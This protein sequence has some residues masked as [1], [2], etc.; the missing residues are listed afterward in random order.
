MPHALLVDD[1]PNFL[2]AL[3]ELIEGQ[4]FI[5]ETAGNLRDARSLLGHRAP[6]VALVDL[7]LP[8]GRGIDL[9]AGQ[10]PGSPTKLVLMTGAAD[11]ESAVQ[12]LRMGA[13]DYL[14]KPLDIGRLKRV[15]ADL[16]AA[17]FEAE[18]DSGP[19][20][21]TAS[22]I[23]E[24]SGLGLLLGTSPPMQE[25]AEMLSR[26]APTDASVL[27]VGESGA[28]KDLAAQTVHLLSRRS[29]APFLPLNCGAISPTLIE[30]ELFGHESGSFTGA[31]RRHKGYFERAHKGTLFLDEI[32]EMPVELQVKLLRVLETGQVM[33]IG[34]DGPVDVDTRVVAATNRD[35]HKLV[36]EGK[37]REDL[38]YR[39]QV[40]PILMPPLRER[41]E[42]IPLLAEHFLGQLNQRHGT[43]KRWTEDAF[44]R[45]R[46]HDWP[47]N[48]RELKNVVHRAYIMADEEIG[49]PSL[50]P[51]IRGAS[52]SRRAFQVGTPLEEVK[53]WLVKSTLEASGGDRRQ[54]AHQLGVSL[55]TLYHLLSGLGQPQEKAPTHS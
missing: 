26:V 48:V 32:T 49:P 35:P 14:T 15:M 53:R 22:A 9:L 3:A 42:D 46:A 8:D 34:G 6:D 18:V 7:H 43:D 17:G 52:Q 11:V 38:L 25:L 5:T 12:A 20:P 16:A 19:A 50:P 37:M 55:P 24:V 4:G 31:E 10:G 44:D 13:S 21:G 33:R 27:L 36:Q 30:S 45:L 2:S 39:L 51:E 28:G 40:F 1:D 41:G 47:G 23:E 29:K 54:A